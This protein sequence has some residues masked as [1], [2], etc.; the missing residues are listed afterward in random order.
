MSDDRTYVARRVYE[1]NGVHI[2]FTRDFSVYTMWKVR[3]P[4]LLLPKSMLSREYYLEKLRLKGLEASVS[5][6]SIQSDADTIAINFENGRVKDISL[7]T[8]LD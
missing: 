1:H 4:G 2:E 5:I 6:I 8:S 3:I 7:E